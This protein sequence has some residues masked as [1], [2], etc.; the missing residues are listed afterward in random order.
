[1]KMTHPAKVTR[2]LSWGMMKR[3]GYLSPRQLFNPLCM[4]WLAIRD[5]RITHED[6]QKTHDWDIPHSVYTE[7]ET[8]VS[9]LSLK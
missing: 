5:E 2:L 9:K 1:M 8:V 3:L 7:I 4:K 6:G